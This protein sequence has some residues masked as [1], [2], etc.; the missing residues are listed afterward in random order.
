MG[1][2]QR[3]ANVPRKATLQDVL[4]APSN[5]VAEVVAGT[6]HARPR[7]KNRHAC[8]SSGLLMKV[9]PPFNYGDGGPG[10]WAI[11]FEPEL[12]F[13]GDIIVPDIAGWRRKSMSENMGDAY[14]TQAPDWVC[15]VLS[16]STRQFDQ[17]DK[18]TVYAREKVLHLW[19]VDPDSRTLEAIELRRG[20]WTLLATLV[21]DD[22]V[23]LPPFDAISFPLDALWPEVLEPAIKDGKDT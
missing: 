20:Q 14:F 13:G 6:L 1:R 16:P 23:S 15:E 21:D 12:H 10:G 22:P 18:R 19:F 11:L 5:L 8:A 3:T 7:P 4:D 9:G 17:G 2:E